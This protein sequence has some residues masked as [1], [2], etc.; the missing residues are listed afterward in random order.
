MHSFTGTRHI[1][2]FPWCPSCDPVS[3]SAAHGISVHQYADDIQTYISL[4]P[5]DMDDLSQVFRWFL[6]SSLLLNPA[7][8]EA[9]VFGTAA[10][11][12]GVESAGS[13]MAAGARVQFVEAIK[14]LGVTLDPTL[15][16]DRHVVA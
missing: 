12:K 14:L 3:T 1:G 5:Q 8:T 2:C 7:K 11:L 6:E 15:S 10:R 13:I 9:V 16:M 4:Y